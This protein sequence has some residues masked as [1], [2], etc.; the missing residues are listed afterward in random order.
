[1]KNNFNIDRYLSEAEEK[2]S[3]FDGDYDD[4]DMEDEMYDGFDDYDMDDDMEDEDDWANASG[5]SAS[6]KSPSPYQITIVNTTAGS[7]TAI[8]FGKNKYLLSTNFG[9]AVGLTVSPAQ[10]NVSYLE[11]LQQSAEQPFE[12]SL[13]RIQSS[14]ATQVTQILTVTVK[15]ANGQSATLPIITQSYFSSYQQQSGILDVPYNLKVDGN[16]NVAFTVLAGATVTLT[17]FPSEKVNIS[18]GLAGKKPVQMYGNPQVNLG[19]M[20]FPKKPRRKVGRTRGRRIGLRKR[21]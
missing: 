20:S 16:T 4:Y 5:G 13:I 3:G 6:A 1:M 21:R 10:S 8:M 18:K 15:D 11:L 14:N 9:S 19:G 2:F 17:L 12:T 7:L